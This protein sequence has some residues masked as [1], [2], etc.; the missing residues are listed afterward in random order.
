M[1]NKNSQQEIFCVVCG[2]IKKTKY[3]EICKK[4]TPNLFEIN[5]SDTI[6]F[7]ESIG[8]KQKRLGFKGFLIKIFQGFK[9]SGDPNLPQGVDEQMIIDREKNEYHQIVKD[10][11]TGKVLHEEHVPLSQ[12]KTNQ[13][14][15]KLI[16]KL[17]S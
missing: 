11:K 14:V 8:I 1:Q 5:V 16:K 6:N 15:E 4:E 7:R 13:K 3:C 2:S 10:N 9:S 17:G 12:H